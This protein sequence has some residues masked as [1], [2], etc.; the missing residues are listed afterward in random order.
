MS[1]ANI[2]YLLGKF[3][4]VGPNTVITTDWKFFRKVLAVRSPYKKS[5]WFAGFRLDPERENLV[6]IVDEEK[7][8]R[9]RCI[10][11]HGVSQTYYCISPVHKH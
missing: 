2:R 9:L 1:K 6:S 8:Q 11:A 7:H 5:Y 4:R 3:T 10:M